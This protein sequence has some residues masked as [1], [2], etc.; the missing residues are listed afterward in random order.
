[1]KLRTKLFELLDACCTA[2]KLSLKTDGIPFRIDLKYHPH[3]L[4][5]LCNLPFSDYTQH[6]RIKRIILSYTSL[7]DVDS[8]KKTVAAIVTYNELIRFFCLRSVGDFHH[9]TSIK[10]LFHALCVAVM[11]DNRILSTILHSFH[12][13]YSLFLTKSYVHNN[14]HM[15]GLPPRRGC[16]TQLPCNMFISCYPLPSES[17]Y[18]CEE[19]AQDNLIHKSTACDHAIQNSKH[20]TNDKYDWAPKLRCRK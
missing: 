8:K 15:L 11:Q 4:E 2:N 13:E 5:T 6:S 7:V 18:M 14:I 12:Y 19:H 3:K 1:M 17:I 16:E 10:A 20:N 9:F